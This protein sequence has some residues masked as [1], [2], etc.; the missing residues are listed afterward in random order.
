MN[1]IKCNNELHVKLTDLAKLLNVT[2][3]RLL[4]AITPRIKE[5]Y[6]ASNI[7]YKIKGLGNTQFVNMKIIKD[8]KIEKDAKV[9]VL[10]NNF[11][12]NNFTL[13]D[14][15]GEIIPKVQKRKPF[16]F[17]INKV[18]SITKQELK[19]IE[20]SNMEV[21]EVTAR[22]RN[23]LKDFGFK[24]DLRTTAT[25]SYNKST[26]KY[27]VF[28]QSIYNTG[29]EICIVA[30][31][32]DAT[33]LIDELKYTLSPLEGNLY[34]SEGFFVTLDDAVSQAEWNITQEEEG[35]ILLDGYS[36]E[37]LWGDDLDLVLRGAHFDFYILDDINTED[38]FELNKITASLVE[39]K[40]VSE[41]KIQL[42][43]DYGILDKTYKEIQLEELPKDRVMY[44]D[45][46]YLYT[47]KDNTKVTKLRYKVCDLIG[48]VI[49]VC[50]DF[51][52]FRHP[53]SILDFTSTVK[54]IYITSME[55]DDEDIEV[56]V[57]IDDDALDELMEFFDK[58]REE[59]K[60]R[61]QQQSYYE[62]Y[63][64]YTNKTISSTYDVNIDKDDL[65]T[66]D[67]IFKAGSMKYHP[68]RNK[69]DDT[70]MVQINNLKDKIFKTNTNK[71]EKVVLQIEQQL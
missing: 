24:G 70:V 2:K 47:K 68:D 45:D 10:D 71:I 69:G 9:T 13:K 55:E 11:F 6:R 53:H 5:E 42:L 43:N 15:E 4:K 16:K 25:V 32:T 12:V 31:A 58:Q 38:K 22:F 56:E 36:V 29:S 19:E 3:A 59:K 30:N 65:N 37:S 57:E 35:V 34:G 48:N 64:K 27:K 41:D 21:Q 1:I 46:V 54:D 28:Y 40:K 14:V 17:N 61:E 60:Q 67:K 50:N 63:F 26:D 44:I 49:E 51:T 7:E 23:T 39:L 33:D 18:R 66:L 52:I 62:K 20:V 8:M